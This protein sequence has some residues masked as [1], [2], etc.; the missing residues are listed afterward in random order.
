[1]TAGDLIER[2]ELEHGAALQAVAG[3]L[4]VVEME[5]SLPPELRQAVRENA[6]ELL[7]AV[8]DSDAEAFGLLLRLRGR[9]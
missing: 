8:E 3:R 5:G 9:A 2:V 7:A 6:G 1:M 4:Y